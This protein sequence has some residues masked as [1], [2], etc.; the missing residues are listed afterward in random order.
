[1]RA[2]AFLLF[3][4]PAT[5]W[6]AFSE[7]PVCYLTHATEDAE[8]VVSHDR[9]KP[10]PYAIEID[11]FETWAQGPVF[12]IQFDGPARNT[13]STGRHQMDAENRKLTVTDRGF[14]NVLNG[15]ER[16]F[17]AVAMT[18]STATVIPLTGAAPEVEKFRNCSAAAGV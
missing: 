13:I 7:G 14:D 4:T 3:A 2:L 12:M 1:M 17:L 11:R 15:I 18:G 9:R 16:N 5:A 10:L 8:V 6:E